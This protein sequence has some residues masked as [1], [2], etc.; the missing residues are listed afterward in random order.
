VYPAK[1]SKLAEE[2]SKTVT[3]IQDLTKQVQDTVRAMTKDATDM[4][5]FI[6]T[7]VDRD[8]KKFMDTANN[9]KADAVTLYE[10]TSKA[11]QQSNQAM[12]AVQQVSQSI[13]EVSQSINQSSEGVQQIAQGTQSTSSAIVEVN[14]SAI[15]LS[16][17]AA[18]LSKMVDKFK[19]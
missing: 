19:V 8:Y 4:L 14:Q 13:E 3:G 17:M 7:D 18:E 15:K 2:S 5:D 10:I 16:E 11:S 9:Y 1:L 6:H 12:A